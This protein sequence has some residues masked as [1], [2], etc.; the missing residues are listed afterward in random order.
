VERATV[1]R[2]IVESVRLTVLAGALAL[3]GCFAHAP[4][5]RDGDP[6]DLGKGSVAMFTLRLENELD[7]GRLPTL[8]DIQVADNDRYHT[9]KLAPP[10][11]ETDEYAEYLISFQFPPGEYWVTDLVGQRDGGPFFLIH[12]TYGIPLRAHAS[13]PKWSYV[14]LGH[15]DVRMADDDVAISV[16]DHYDADVELAKRLYRVPAAKDVLNQTPKPRKRSR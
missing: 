6:V 14:Y 10:Y 11:N 3:T 4:L 8:T 2:D 7:P 15:F 5:E 9:V 13:L 12:Y 1:L 16:Q